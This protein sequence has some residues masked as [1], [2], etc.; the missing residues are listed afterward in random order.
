M[1]SCCLVFERSSGEVILTQEPH[2]FVMNTHTEVCGECGSTE[3]Q[4]LK[5][6]SFCKHVRYCGVGCQASAAF[7]NRQ[8]WKQRHSKECTVLTKINKDGRVLTTTLRLVLQMLLKRHQQK[9]SK[10]EI[11][12]WDHYSLVS[13][14]ETH[15]KDLPEDRLLQF[16]QMA[17]L[18]GSITPEE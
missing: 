11:K 18:L 2:A 6:C 1:L 12:P 16:A 14:L 10:E 9:H 4:S 5:R 17:T 13:L 3:A 15:R 7:P 8:A